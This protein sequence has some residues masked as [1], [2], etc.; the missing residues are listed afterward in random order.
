MAMKMYGLLLFGAG[1]GGMSAWQFHRYFWKKDLLQARE[2]R[3]QGP[4]MAGRLDSDPPEDIAP[5]RIEGTFYNADAVLVGPKRSTATVYGK[6]ETAES[7]MVYVPFITKDNQHILVCKG[8]VPADIIESGRL[9]EVLASWPTHAAVEGVFRKPEAPPAHAVVKRDEGLYKYSHPG[10]IWTDFYDRHG[11]KEGARKPLSYWIDVTGQPFDTPDNLP[12][13]RDKLS[14]AAHVI[15]PP[16]HLVYFLTWTALFG[17]AMWNLQR[18]A[19]RLYKEGLGT[20]KQFL[21]NLTNESTM[22]W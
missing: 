15:T 22:K 17:V 4:P 20:R 3:L 21:G 5:V 18:H 16:V 7:Y 9:Q 10:M 13:T 2:E 8:Q 11:I 1:T 12:L 14:Y 6:V 19:P